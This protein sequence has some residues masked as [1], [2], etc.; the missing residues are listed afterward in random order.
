MVVSFGTFNLGTIHLPQHWRTLH[1][2]RCPGTIRSPHGD[3]AA[4]P[5]LP[6]AVATACR[7]ACTGRE[8]VKQGWLGFLAASL[9]AS[10]QASELNITL[11]ALDFESFHWLFYVV[12]ELSSLLVECVNRRYLTHHLSTQSRQIQPHTQHKQ[13]RCIQCIIFCPGESLQ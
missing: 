11:D 8:Q 13:T 6:M 7:C 2:L 12:R 4:W 3:T 5:E 10:M 9:S 1:Y